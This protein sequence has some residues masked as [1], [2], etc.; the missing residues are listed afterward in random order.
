[1]EIK[2]NGLRKFITIESLLRHQLVN[3]YPTYEIKKVSIYRLT[4]NADLDYDEEEAQDLLVKIEN[5]IQ[6][7][8]WGKA[9]RIELEESP[10]NPVLEILK[11][12]VF[13]IR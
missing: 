1:M 10:S 4:R 5:S 11:N 12:K 9:V 7:R 2:E 8:K 3:L 6:K 13:G